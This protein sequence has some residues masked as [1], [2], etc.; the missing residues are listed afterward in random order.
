MS[1]SADIER[2]VNELREQIE[3]HNYRYHVLDD[4]EIPDPEY[5][6][7]MRTLEALE[8]EHPSL[9]TPDSPTQRVGATPLAAFGEVLHSVPMLSLGNA[10]DEQEVV[11]FDRRVRERLGVEEVDYTAETKMDG[12]AV[13]VRYENGSLV[14]AAT[15]GDGTKGEDVT[16]NVRTV[17]A[18]PLR[19]RGAKP[20]AVLEARGEVFMTSA[21]FKQLNDEQRE[22]EEKEFANPRNAAAGSLRQLDS[23]ITASRPLTCFCYGVGE[24]AGVEL[25]GKHFDV[26]MYLRELG[27]PVSPETRVVTG[28]AGCIDYFERIGARRDT[29]G[30]EIDGVVYKV[31]A[32]EQQQAL[33]FVSRAPRWALAHKYPAQEAL[34]RV[35][36]IDV[37]VGRTGA[38]TP[39]ARLEP[40]HVGG[41]TVTNATLHNQD[42]VERKDVRGGDTVYVRRAGDVIPEVVRVV[43]ERRPKGTKPYRL[44]NR[45][46]VCNSEAMR[47]EGEAVVR[48]TGGLYCPAQRK[49]AI[50]HFASR[51]AVDIEGLG[52]KLVDQ[53]VEQGV[54]ETVPDLYDLD[55]DT[56]RALE[57][58]AEKSARNLLA[59]LERSKTTSLERFLY[60]L[61]IPDV[62]E[63]TAQT[64]AVYFGSL[65]RLI[66]A[67]DDA[68]QAVPD[69]GPV[70][71]REIRSFFSQPH[72]MEVLER[73]RQRMSI[74]SRVAPVEQSQPLAGKTVVI[75]GTLATMTRDEAKKRLLAL[76]AKVTGS[77]SAK[78]SFLVAGADPGSKLAKATQHGVQV[79]DEDALLR[80]LEES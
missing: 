45:C 16:Q 61:G 73:L 78:T 65:D 41:V 44:P 36:G 24:V 56:L 63:T 55:L 30:Y 29:L 38:L 54:V 11:E 4:P 42:E 69:V 68:L 8:T 50:R 19:L 26:L 39:V 35:V 46:P 32:I 34:T 47:A 33:G 77:I 57:R 59:A 21:G 27:L 14:Q 18:L 1:V 22:R 64:L 31:N 52:E 7:L 70:V 80:L 58:M 9:L 13:S 62:G 75:T 71:A 40:V 43:L 67:D 37:Q 72:N 6:R 53:L 49:Q 12:L 17:K 28:V 10:F 25:P 5:D 66:E 48:C 74:E 3:Y 23:K 60:G 15:R 79:L 2:R 20:P 51:R 76:G